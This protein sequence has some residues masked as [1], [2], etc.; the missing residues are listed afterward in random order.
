MLQTILWQTYIFIQ[1]RSLVRAEGILTQLIFEHTLR[2]RQ[3]ADVSAEKA[4]AQQEP[5]ESTAAGTPDSASIADSSA[6]NNHSQGQGSE[7]TTVVSR[8]AS[9]SSLGSP[10]KAKSTPVPKEPQEKKKSSNMMGTINNLLTTDL[11]NITDAR[12]FMMVGE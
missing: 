6:S 12:D 4:K 5:S 11:T 9:T 1:T 2:I 7:S 8:E 3:K 10:K